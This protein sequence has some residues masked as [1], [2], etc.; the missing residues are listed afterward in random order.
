MHFFIKKVINVMIRKLYGKSSNGVDSRE[1]EIY[2]H[3]EKDKKWWNMTVLFD[4]ITKE[5]KFKLD[6]YENYK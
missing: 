5:F 3:R 6:A 2:F 1:S 4:K